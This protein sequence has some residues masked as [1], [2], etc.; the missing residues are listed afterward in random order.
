[1]ANRTLIIIGIGLA[2]AL[3]VG[4]MVGVASRSTAVVAEAPPSTPSKTRS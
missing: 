2:G 1:M 3:V 4:Y